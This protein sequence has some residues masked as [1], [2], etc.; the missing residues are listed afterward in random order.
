MDQSL[1][2]FQQWPVDSKGTC[3]L[4]HHGHFG[5]KRGRQL[6]GIRGPGPILQ[7][8][9]EC[10]HGHP[11]HNLHWS[12]RIWC[13]R[14]HASDSCLACGSCLLGHSTDSQDPSG[15]SLAE[16]QE[17]ET[18]KIFLV[19]LYQHVSIRGSAG[20]CVPLAEFRFHSGMY[21]I[22]SY[23]P[24]KPFCMPLS[25]FYNVVSRIHEGNWK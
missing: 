15:A 22:N 12:V 9:T 8:A 16:P 6:S 13:L 18:D 7:Y 1:E 19:C 21:Q 5:L 2:V 17:L 3:N 4:C 11:E 14:C 20:L 25:F 23:L 24:Y 10:N